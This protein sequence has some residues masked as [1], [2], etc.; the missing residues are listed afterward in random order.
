MSMNEWT[1]LS[2]KR[3]KEGKIGR[4]LV[5]ISAYHVIVMD[6]RQAVKWA[7]SVQEYVGLGQLGLVLPT[8][9]QPLVGLVLQEIDN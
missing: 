6:D 1:K 5:C 3:M 9:L 7:M 2:R 4:A 8:S